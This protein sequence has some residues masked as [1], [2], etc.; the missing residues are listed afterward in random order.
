M[1]L[2]PHFYSEGAVRVI[3]LLDDCDGIRREA[4]GGRNYMDIDPRRFPESHL[5]AKHG[6]F[7]WADALAQPVLALDDDAQSNCPTERVREDAID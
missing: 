5:L 1:T 3:L 4:S 6:D 7:R 2:R